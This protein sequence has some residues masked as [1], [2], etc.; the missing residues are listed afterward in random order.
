MKILKQVGILFGL[1]WAAQWIERALPFPFPASVI[2][3]M[4]L[5]ALLLTRVIRPEHLREETEFLLN[6]LPFFFVPA[7]VGILEYTDLILNNAAA[8]LTVCVGSLILTFG[9]TAWAVTLTV[10][11]ME[12]RARK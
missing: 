8:F 11:A 7:A 2:G 4:L 12:R 9:A 3:L 10:R 1:C 5:L 6:N